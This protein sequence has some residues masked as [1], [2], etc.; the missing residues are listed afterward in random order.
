MPHLKRVEAQSDAESAISTPSEDEITE[1]LDALK[2]AFTALRR[3][4]K[5]QRKELANVQ[6][7]NQVLRVSVAATPSG[8]TTSKRIKN[9]ERELAATKK[10]RIDSS[11]VGLL[12]SRVQLSQQEAAKYKAKY[13]KLHADEVRRERHELDGDVFG[14]GHAWEDRYLSMKKLLRRFRSL[15]EEVVLEDPGEDGKF[16]EC[17]VC[18]DALSR[19]TTAALPCEH[20]FHMDCIRELDK[21]ARSDE[22]QL[23]CPTCREPCNMED[24]FHVTKTAG[25]QWQQLTDVAT[26]WANMDLQK[27][28]VDTETEDRTSEP[29]FI[30]NDMESVEEESEDDRLHHSASTSHSAHDNRGRRVETEMSHARTPSTVQK[31]RRL[32]ELVAARSAKK[33]RR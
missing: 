28:E 8:N 19:E 11:N 14:G 12:N 16:P 25:E 21:H 15:M 13:N 17:P 10:V 23:T 4:R 3:E 6:Q 32:D 5:R 29:S 24:I 9:L 7:A 27:D 33:A 31:R 22:K 18:Y 20:M 1:K 30:E 2:E 26:E